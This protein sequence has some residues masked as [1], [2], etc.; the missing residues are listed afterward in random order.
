MNRGRSAGRRWIGRW[1]LGI[2]VRPL[3]TRWGERGLTLHRYYLESF[4]EHTEQRIRGRCLE[5]QR[6]V[7]TSRFGKDRIVS[8]DI[9]NKAPG[10][11]DEATIIADLTK[12]NDVH[13]GLFDC[14]VC[15][16]VL[17]LVHDPNRMIA[18]LHRLLAPGGTLLASVP[19]ITIR[20]PEYGELWR[21][22]AEGFRALLQRH[23]EN[24]DVAVS[25]YGNSLIAAGELRGLVLSDFSK[26]EYDFHDPR[27]SI[28]ICAQAIKR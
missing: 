11:S 1:R 18:E 19:D 4:L 12:P 16:Y 24:G 26:A 15:T 27:Y 22:T 17:H 2:G 21:F 3:S 14:I 20:Y 5:F 9:L 25:G 7:Y 28:V 6:D 13:G 10:E 23:F 8:I